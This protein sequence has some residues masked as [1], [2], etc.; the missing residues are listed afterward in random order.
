MRRKSG[1]PLLFHFRSIFPH[2]LLQLFL[3]KCKVLGNTTV[4]CGRLT[5]FL[6]RRCNLKFTKIKLICRGDNESAVTSSVYKFDGENLSDGNDSQNLSEGHSASAEDKE[7]AIPHFEKETEAVVN[8]PPKKRK[9][10]ATPKSKKKTP[11]K[12]SVQHRLPTNGG[13]VIIN[14]TT[15]P[16]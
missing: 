15:S 16:Q 10:S 6:N 5:I 8:I 11:P 4:A 13:S 12:R 1:A 2:L 3:S 7:P 14:I 9:R